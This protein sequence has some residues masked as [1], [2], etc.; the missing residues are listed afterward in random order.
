MSLDNL[1][2]DTQLMDLWL[3]FKEENAKLETTFKQMN[4]Y[5]D[6]IIKN[7]NFG[8]DENHGDAHDLKLLMDVQDFLRTTKVPIVTTVTTKEPE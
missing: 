7:K 5:A 8:K 3:A 1:V 6:L 2:V 4:H